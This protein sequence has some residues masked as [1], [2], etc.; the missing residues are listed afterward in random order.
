VNRRHD[1]APGALGWSGRLSSAALA[2]S[3]LGIALRPQAALDVLGLATTSN[4]GIAET[5]AGLGGTFLA[6][7]LWA[8]RHGSPDA[9]TAVGMTWLGAGAF[10]TLSLVIDDPET[11]WTYWAYLAA[12]LVLGL[13]AIAAGTRH[14][15]EG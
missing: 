11:D 8:L 1:R 13:G 9:S 6:L 2:A 15:Y 7:G 10:R 3:G 12:E 4:R 5:R 14:R